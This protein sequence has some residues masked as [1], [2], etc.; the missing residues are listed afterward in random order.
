MRHL[1]PTLPAPRRALGQM[2]HLPPFLPPH[3]ATREISGHAPIQAIS[4]SPT[5]R[6][7]T[8]MPPIPICPDCFGTY[9]PAE[10]ETSAPSGTIDLVISEIIVA[11]TSGTSYEG[12]GYI[13]ATTRVRNTSGPAGACVVVTAKNIGTKSASSVRLDMWADATATPKVGDTSSSH[14]TLS[15]LAGRKSSTVVFCGLAVPEASVDLVV[16]TGKSV[17]EY[18]E[19]NNGRSVFY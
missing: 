17:T 14:G 2:R 16:D 18:R 12:C 4:G 11:Q 3:R 13:M 7:K 9:I 1:P 10:V 8:P 15:S 6:E 19:T 5:T